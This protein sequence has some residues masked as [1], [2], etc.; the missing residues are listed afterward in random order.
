[1]KWPHDLDGEMRYVEFYVVNDYT[2]VS[3]TD[4]R[5]DHIANQ[6]RGLSKSNKIDCKTI[7]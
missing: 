5:V 7:V 1:L 2:Q 4:Y 3:D 6:L